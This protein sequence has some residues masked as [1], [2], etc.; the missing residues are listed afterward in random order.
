MDDNTSKEG[1]KEE[2]D[3][4]MKHESTGNYGVDRDYS[5]SSWQFKE[6]KNEG[7]NKIDFDRMGMETRW[8]DIIQ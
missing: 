6:W 4:R 5:F 8:K 7:K 2:S 1:N 3:G